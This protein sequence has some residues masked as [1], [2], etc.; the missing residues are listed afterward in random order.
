VQSSTIPNVSSSS[1]T[2]TYP[3]KDM[4]VSRK[5]GFT[6]GGTY[7]SL[8]SDTIWILDH[9]DVYYVDTEATLAGGNWSASDQP[10]GSPSDQLPFPLTMVAVLANPD[11]ARHLSALGHSVSNSTPQLPLGC[12]QFG[13]VTLNVSRN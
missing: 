5:Q 2:L 11:C 3:G 8:G 6:A 12:T 1:A 10:L 4:Q 9:T 13:Q 7:S